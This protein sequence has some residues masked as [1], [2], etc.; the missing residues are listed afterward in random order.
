MQNSLEE[1]LRILRALDEDILSV[2]ETDDIATDI[3]ETETV[4]SRK[5]ESIELCR[6]VIEGINSSETEERALETR[7]STPSVLHKEDGGGHSEDRAISPESTVR[8]NPR[9]DLV[10]T[11]A[12]EGMSPSSTAR[13]SV[14]VP[15]VPNP[16]CQS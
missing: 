3:E 4:N 8:E 5:T 6:R 16:S 11:V 13:S 1:K 12:T 2:C 14:V 9:T 7:A 15:V 10:S